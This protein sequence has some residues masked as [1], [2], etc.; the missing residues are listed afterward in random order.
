MSCKYLYAYKLSLS[1]S[2]YNDI[3]WSSEGGGA[4]PPI[5]WLAGCKL[6]VDQKDVV[7][8]RSQTNMM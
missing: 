8:L 7:N 4:R 5:S 1:C 3:Q 2:K 6:K